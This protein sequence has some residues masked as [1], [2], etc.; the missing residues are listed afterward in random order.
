MWSP[1]RARRTVRRRLTWAVAIAVTLSLLVVGTTLYI[2]ESRRIDQ[3]IDAA[4][5]QELGEFRSLQRDVDPAT[6]QPF[7]SAERVL[8][9]FLERNLPDEN[10][11]LFTFAPTGGPSYQGQGDP[12]LQRSPEF[13]ATVN[14]LRDSGGTRTVRAGSDTYRIAVQPVVDST[15]T[16]AFVVSHN[17]SER[18][19]PL[20]ELMITYALLGALA[21]LLVAGL[22]SWIVGRLLRPLQSLQ[23]TARNINE[24]DLSTRA[25]VSTYDDVGELQTAFNDMLDR[26]ETAFTAQRQLLDDA[27][28]ELRTPLTVLQGH[29]E[30]I[31]PNDPADVE[32]SHRLLLDEIG[33]MSGLVDDLLVLAKARRPDFV[34]PSATDIGALTV[35]V[36]DRARVLGDRDWVLDETAEVTV[37]AD[38][39]RLTQALLQLCHNAVKYTQPGDTVGI[40]SRHNGDHVDLW[41][42]DTGPGVDPDVQER[43]FDRFSQG[44]SATDGYGLGLSIVHA[45]ATAHGGDITLDEAPPGGGAMFRLRLPLRG[46]A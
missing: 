16:S 3:S 45:I 37:Q 44:S 21:V 4:L 12:Q 8:I 22:A 11:S 17:V 36:L 13:T 23:R 26:V 38:E 33:R 5:T 1:L 34:D 46:P 43:L 18:Q 20:R 30:V 10:E 2:V 42:R 27:G 40:G 25:E 24:G 7:A 31:D 9:V 29:L 6:R 32:T 28:H 39:R 41:V 15:G 19:A 14:D 35:G